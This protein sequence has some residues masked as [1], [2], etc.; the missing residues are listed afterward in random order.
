MHSVVDI[1]LV[2]DLWRN[3]GS[4]FIFHI[5]H[6]FI[7]LDVL[8]Q[9]RIYFGDDIVITFFLFDHLYFLHVFLFPNFLF[10]SLLLRVL[11]SRA[12]FLLGLSRFGKLRITCIVNFFLWWLFVKMELLQDLLLSGHLC[13]S[14]NNLYFSIHFPIIDQQVCT[15]ASFFLFPFEII[16]KSWDS[17]TEAFRL[18]TV[19]AEQAN[20]GI[21][22]LQP[23]VILSLNER[24]VMSRF[25]ISN[26]DNNSSQFI[27][28]ITEI[29]AMLLRSLL[30][31]KVLQCIRIYV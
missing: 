17:S 18:D 16:L 31:V 5:D 22:K 6:Y 15:F 9:H 30:P 11:K 12:C 4:N 20:Q 21:I 27:V 23:S 28:I 2:L 26:V 29:L 24:Y 10:I 3:I 19:D 1:D 25:R 7:I 14:E 8:L 13:L